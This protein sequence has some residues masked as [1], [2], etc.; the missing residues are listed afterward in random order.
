MSDPQDYSAV[1]EVGYD[2]GRADGFNLALALLRIQ[3]DYYPNECPNSARAFVPD[4]FAESACSLLTMW[5]NA[6][7]ELERK[8][9]SDQRVVAQFD[10][11]LREAL[12]LKEAN[13]AEPTL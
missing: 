1:F 2:K 13:N 10:K 9:V 8:R 5:G 12:H 4:D 7:I 6:L 11:Q 3:I